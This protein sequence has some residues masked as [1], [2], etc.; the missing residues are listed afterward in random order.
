MGILGQ[1]QLGLLVST[2]ILIPSDRVLNSTTRSYLKFWI[3]NFF[4]KTGY[5]YSL[6]NLKYTHSSK[7]RGGCECQTA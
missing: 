1:K 6:S 4:N 2:R 7:W 3:H 5:I